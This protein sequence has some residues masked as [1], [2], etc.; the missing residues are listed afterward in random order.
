MQKPQQNIS[1]GNPYDCLIWSRKTIFDEF[2]SCSFKKQH[3]Q[4]SGNILNLIQGIYLKLTTNNGENDK[5]FTL[6][7]CRPI[8]KLSL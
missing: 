7:K 3:C 4:H 1:R 6:P 2:N 8:H 5:L